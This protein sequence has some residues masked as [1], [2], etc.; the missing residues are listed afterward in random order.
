[1]SRL[2]ALVATT[3]ASLFIS[4]LPP[5][6]ALKQLKTSFSRTAPGSMRQDG[7]P[8]GRPSDDARLQGVDGPGTWRPVPAD[9][10]AATKRVLDMQDGPTILVGH[11]YGGSVITEA[12]VHPKVVGLVYVAAHAPDVGGGRPARKEV[13]E[14]VL[15]RTAG[16]IKTT[17]DG[18]TYL[19]PDLFPDLFAPDLPRERASFAARS[20]VLAKAE[21]FTAP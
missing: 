5:L 14:G 13:A 18:Y 9:D 6:L 16:A 3:L 12:G 19:D 21:V 7:K 11:S 1:M 15:A 17:S 8:A 2:Y 4:L 10:V 20:Q